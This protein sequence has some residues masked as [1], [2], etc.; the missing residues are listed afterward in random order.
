M[1]AAWSAALAEAESAA[2]ASLHSLLQERSRVDSERAALDD[3]RGAL[4]PDARGRSPR[5]NT[6]ALRRLV[7]NRPL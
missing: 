7:E 3:L 1:S 4:Q 6:D 5:G 2:R